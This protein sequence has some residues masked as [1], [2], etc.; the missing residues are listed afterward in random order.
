MLA[1]LGYRLLSLV[2]FQDL[3]PG[4]LVIEESP[5]LSTKLNE[6]GDMLGKFHPK[7]KEFI[8]ND[9]IR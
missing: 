3:E 8:C 5:L 9:L 6:E 4:D 7:T 1:L 2:F